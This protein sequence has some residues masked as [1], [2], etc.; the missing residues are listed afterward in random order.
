MKEKF[1]RVHLLSFLGLVTA[2]FLST[3]FSAPNEEVEIM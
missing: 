3:L 1:G 2:L